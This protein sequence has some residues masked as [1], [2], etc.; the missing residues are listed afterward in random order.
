MSVFLAD[1]AHQLLTELDL[2]I[3]QA[4]RSAYAVGTGHNLRS[5]WKSYLLF[6]CF[7]SLCP[8]PTSVVD[9]CRYILFLANNLKVYQ[10]VKN[11]LN[12]VRVLHG[13]HGLPFTML[14][15]FEVRLVLQAVKRR[16]RQAPF[17]K[18]PIEPYLLRQIYVQLNMNNSYHASLW[19]SF[20]LAFYAFLR[21]SNV[22]P[23]SLDS[24]DCRKHLSRGSVVRTYYGLCLTLKWSKTNQYGERSLQ[25]PIA[26]IPGDILDP[27]AAFDN[28]CRLA[29]R[30]A[31]CPAFAYRNRRAFA[32]YYVCRVYKRVVIMYSENG[33]GPG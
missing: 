30:D 3:T 10:S 2:E 14:Q 6:Y 28:M 5:Q 8:L 31:Q 7:C 19:C 1:L 11:Y 18:L 26:E 32:I 21:K 29:K 27:V 4:K 24:Y 25:I 15:H 13:C 22:V 16:L 20:L 33:F 17:A 23:R 12:G 9:L